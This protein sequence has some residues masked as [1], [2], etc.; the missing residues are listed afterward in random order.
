MRHFAIAIDGDSGA[1]KGTLAE[2]LAAHYNTQYLPTGNLYRALAKLIL[3]AGI[4]YC[5]E[6]AVYEQIHNIDTQDIFSKDLGTQKIAEVAS[7][8]AGF[9]S[10]RSSLNKYQV[11]WSKRHKIAILEGRDIGTTILPDADVKI[12]LTASLNARAKRRFA[13]LVN[14]NL[15]G[16]IKNLSEE[17]IKHEL[18][19][20]DIRD[21][22]RVNSP[23]C[24]PK[25]AYIID[26]TNL[27]QEAVFNLAI[28]HIQR[29]VLD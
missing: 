17:T 4:N 7:K 27:S 18:Q 20:R 9:S 25:D 1:G 28:K 29:F 2:A 24:I 5:D 15:T 8:I 13:Q 10:V 14:T 16:A 11:D 21:K 23:L 22:N 12:Y 3:E 26:S 6:N 19:K